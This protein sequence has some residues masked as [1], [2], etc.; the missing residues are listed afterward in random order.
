GA[1]FARFFEKK[2]Y[3]TGGIDDLDREYATPKR[4]IVQKLLFK[5][6][7]FFA[8]RCLIVSKAD[9]Q[10]IKHIFSRNRK[11][12]K[13][14][15]CYHTIDVKK[16]QYT[17]NPTKENFFTTIVWMG[18]RNNVERKGVDRSL[19]VFKLFKRKYP[20][21][22]NYKYIIIGR[23]GD[24]TTYLKELCQNLSIEN[25]VIFSGEIDEDSKIK[26]LKKSRFYFQLSKYEGFGIAALEALTAHNIVINSGKGG[27]KDCVGKFG[28]H[29]DLA[30]SPENQ[31]DKIQHEINMKNL[32]SFEECDR[33]IGDRFSHFI[34][35]S[36]LNKIIR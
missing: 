19:E 24:G 7:Y 1:F 27:L 22:E 12:D 8:D 2:I 3:F 5:F 10:N 35:K 31:I 15:L 6:C 32:S 11:L 13:L 25:D 34:R 21:Y 14:V 33:Y 29:Y 23:E 16:N 17:G 30:M 20:E 18:N 28:I 4:Y 36:L 26:Y 9:V